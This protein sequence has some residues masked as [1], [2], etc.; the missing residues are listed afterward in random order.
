MDLEVAASRLV[1][2]VFAANDWFRWLPDPDVVVIG[3]S[4]SHSD[5]ISRRMETLLDLQPNGK[6]LKEHVSGGS[7]RGELLRTRLW[8]STCFPIMLRRD[9]SISL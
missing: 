6:H 3:R 9:R 7:W 4:G 5:R 1:L 2:L 8:L